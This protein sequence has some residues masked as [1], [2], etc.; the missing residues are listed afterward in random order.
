MAS[1]SLLRPRKPGSTGKHRIETL[2]HAV[3]DYFADPRLYPSGNSNLIRPCG[4]NVAASGGRRI[5]MAEQGSPINHCTSKS[6]A[7]QEKSIEKHEHI[8][9]QFNDE[10]LTALL[11]NPKR[12]PANPYQYQ[13]GTVVS[14][15]AELRAVVV[16]QKGLQRFNPLNVPIT[17]KV[18]EKI[19]LYLEL[20]F[21]GDDDKALKAACE[22]ALRIA[23]GDAKIKMY[24]VQEVSD[25]EDR[26]PVFLKW[27]VSQKMLSPALNGKSKNCFIK[28]YKKGQRIRLEILVR[29]PHRKRSTRQELDDLLKLGGP[30]SLANEAMEI[31]DIIASCLRTIEKHARK[32]LSEI[33]YQTPSDI[34][35]QDMVAR[36]R[37]LISRK[38]DSVNLLKALRSIGDNGF[39]DKKTY[40]SLGL[41][42]QNL[43]LLADPEF[44]FLKI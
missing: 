35:F 17:G 13:L 10:E 19:E 42:V 25:G 3:V 4:R 6:R 23:F 38:A 5:I 29:N 43:S 26:D 34:L 15:L 24:N 44:G 21:A 41:N 27:P 22:K 20:P 12:H 14:N 1:A 18:L 30:P 16:E 37:V 2:D 7:P 33:P 39:I 11:M 9:N 31:A 40:R 8:Y 28:F 32:L 36:C